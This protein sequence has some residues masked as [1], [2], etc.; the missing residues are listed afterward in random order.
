MTQIEE[1]PQMTQMTQMISLN[2]TDHLRSLVNLRIRL[3][4]VIR[5]VIR[6][7]SG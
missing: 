3:L 6:H 2:S 5:C 7:S 4:C 1:E